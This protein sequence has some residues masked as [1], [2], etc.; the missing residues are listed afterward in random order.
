MNLISK[1]QFV[2]STLILISALIVFF[3][4]KQSRVNAS[5]GTVVPGSLEA[6]AQD[7]AA[8]GIQSIDVNT[9]LWEYEGIA[10]I[11][12]ALSKYSVII[13]HPVSNTSYVWNSELQIVGTWYKFAV[14]ESLA[15]RPHIV[16]DMCETDPP[17]SL[18]P[19]N[20][21]QLLISKYGGSVIINGV[22][23]RSIDTD[24]PAYQTSQDYLIFLDVDQTKGVGNVDGGGAAVFAIGTNSV[25]TPVSSINSEL[26]DDIALRY[27][28]S[29]TALRAALGGSAPTT[30]PTPTPS[31]C[32]ASNTLIS[33][34]LNNGGDW[35]YQTCQCSQ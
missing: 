26:A 11:D 3:V 10:G 27:G 29:L 6:L 19:L 15:Q 35:D 2:A 23:I 14:T 24:F 7:C 17:A 12:E 1:K 9:M 33:R 34:C 30:T 20:N 4:Y 18:L 16:C 32:T 31:P 25:L 5:Q 28:N 21:G 22:T 8:N 13:A